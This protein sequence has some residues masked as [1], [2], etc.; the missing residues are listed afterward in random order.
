MP[1]ETDKETYEKGRFSQRRQSVFFYQIRRIRDKS[2]LQ[3][4]DLLYYNNSQC[5]NITYIT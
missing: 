1:E 2:F 5:D 3:K 4:M